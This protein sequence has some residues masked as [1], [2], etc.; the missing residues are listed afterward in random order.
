MPIIDVQARQKEVDRVV[1]AE[2]QVRRIIQRGLQHPHHYVPQFDDIDNDSNLENASKI[3]II[4]LPP[5]LLR[6][7]F[8]IT[9]AI[10][11]L[12]NLKGALISLSVTN[13]NFHSM[14]FVEIFKF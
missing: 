3:G 2:E 7:K 6:I 11:L 8:D 4:V 5:L 13:E 1:V 9:S 10:I 12:L 14:N